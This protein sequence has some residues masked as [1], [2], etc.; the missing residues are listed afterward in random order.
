MIFG[1]PIMQLL[2]FGCVI[3]SDPQSLPA[4]VVMADD[5]PAGRSLVAG[6]ANSSFYDFIRRAASEEEARNGCSGARFSLC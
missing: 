5:G 6:F 3:N 1:I 2:L 4:A